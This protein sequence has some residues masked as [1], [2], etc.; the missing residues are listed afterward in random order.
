MEVAASGIAVASL[1][2]QLIQTADTIKTFIRDVKGAPAELQRVSQTL[3]ALRATLE[4][5]RS[6]IEF[7]SSRLGQHVPPPSSAL[8]A[9]LHRCE[10]HLKPLK[11]IVNEYGPIL[12]SPSQRPR[13]WDKIKFNFKTK[14]DI[15]AFEKRIKETMSIINVGLT[16]NNT[17]IQ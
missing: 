17:L 6:V 14:E 10:N 12:Q 11:K 9:S 8:V 7:Q 3:D 13:K 4:D 16:T 15:I 1:A 2:L 5:V